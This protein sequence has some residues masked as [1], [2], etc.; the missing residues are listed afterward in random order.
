VALVGTRVVQP[1][2]AGCRLAQAVYN[3]A[4][5]EWGIADL[6]CRA[7]VETVLQLSLSMGYRRKS[8]EDFAYLTWRCTIL[9][10][11]SEQLVPSWRL[12]KCHRG[13]FG[14]LG[15]EPSARHPSDHPDASASGV[16]AFPEP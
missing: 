3:A 16:P 5:K 12:L 6:I 14:L 9:G 4:Q 1:T 11:T 8:N 15:V 2:A 10:L 7:V 13:T